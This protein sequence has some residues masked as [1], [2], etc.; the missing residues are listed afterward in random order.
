MVHRTKHQ[1][2]RTRTHS[3]KKAERRQIGDPGHG[4]GAHP[5]DRPRQNRVDHPLVHCPGIELV[6][7]EFHHSLPFPAEQEM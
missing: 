1:R 6:W 3:L 2:R 7:I 4:H 5:S